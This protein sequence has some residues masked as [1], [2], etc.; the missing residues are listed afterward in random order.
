MQEKREGWLKNNIETVKTLEQK[1]TI[2]VNSFKPKSHDFLKSKAE[3]LNDLRVLCQSCRVKRKS[4]Q[5]GCNQAEK[6]QIAS[7]RSNWLI[8]RR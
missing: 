5:S 4:M 2:L 8:L 6:R 7:Y 3:T 1:V